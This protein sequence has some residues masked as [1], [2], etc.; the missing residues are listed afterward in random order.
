MI[1]L[2]HV[3]L[4]VICA[5]KCFTLSQ[6]VHQIFGFTSKYWKCTEVSTTVFIYIRIE[7]QISYIELKSIDSAFIFLRMFGEKQKRYLYIL[8]K[9]MIFVLIVYDL[10][11]IWL[12]C[13]L[14]SCIELWFRTWLKVKYNK[15]LNM[16]ISLSF[17]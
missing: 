3:L 17:W 1:L 16:N 11:V 13:H 4:L 12:C 7:M 10:L 9:S 8:I 5:Y 14:Q 15:H 6:D 2:C